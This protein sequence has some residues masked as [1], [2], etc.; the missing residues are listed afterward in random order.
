MKRIL[1]VMAAMLFVVGISGAATAQDGPQITVVGNGTVTAKPD[2]LRIMVG[3]VAHA[4][5][6]SDAV[7]MMSD[8][9][10][11]VI[12]VMGDEGLPPADIQ[13]SGLQLSERYSNDRD[14]DAPPKV[15]GFTAQSNVTVVVRDLDRAGGILDRLVTEGA[16]QISGLQFDID[17]KAPLLERARVAAVADAIAK[18]T[19][20]ADA[21][22]VKAGAIVSIS[23]A[24]RGGGFERGQMLAMAD[25]RSVPIAAGTLDI[26]AQVTVVTAID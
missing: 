15:V 26:T 8:D 6:A 24:S 1:I 7:R 12:A 22:N 2:I 23:E 13:T 4:D 9:L 11:Q 3:V 21:A 19:L 16:N 20:Y 5:Q 25:A 17:D 10:E 14:Y 18:T